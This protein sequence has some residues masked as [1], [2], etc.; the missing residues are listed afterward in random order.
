MKI[1]TDPIHTAHLKGR[2][3][4]EMLSRPW[5]V[6]SKHALQDLQL[7]GDAPP[8][9]NPLI[10]AAAKGY[11]YLTSVELEL[12]MLQR[13]VNGEVARR[14]AGLLADVQSIKARWPITLI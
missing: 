6:V 12:K 4:E 8:D 5:P 14:A 13:S 11:V 9:W 3:P 1:Q 10:H 2:H 7:T